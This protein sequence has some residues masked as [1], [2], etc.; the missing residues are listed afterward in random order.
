MLVLY[1]Q[2]GL[3]KS[4]L[5]RHRVV[6][7]LLIRAPLQLQQACCLDR[8]YHHGHEVLLSSEVADVQRRRLHELDE[9]LTDRRFRARLRRR[10]SDAARRWLVPVVACAAA[11]ALLAVGLLVVSRRRVQRERAQEERRQ[12]HAA[13]LSFDALAGSP[14][15]SPSMDTRLLSGSVYSV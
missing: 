13:T 10:D 15:R 9:R 11:A 5:R 8:A 6:S 4:G 12:H 14:Q 2:K 3:A 1:L 7:R